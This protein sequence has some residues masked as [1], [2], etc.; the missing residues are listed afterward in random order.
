M[1]LREGRGLR[2]SGDE[3]R[4]VAVLELFF[5]QGR[6]GGGEGGS[7]YVLPSTLNASVS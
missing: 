2:I 1:G 7:Y 6:R 4:A 5:L 3:K